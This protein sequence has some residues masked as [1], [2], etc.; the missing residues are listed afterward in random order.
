VKLNIALWNMAIQRQ[1]EEDLLWYSLI[2]EPP[3]V[4]E[5]KA[6]VVLWMSHKAAS[7]GTKILQTP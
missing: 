3:D 7:L 1:G 6:P 4:L 5:P 2:N